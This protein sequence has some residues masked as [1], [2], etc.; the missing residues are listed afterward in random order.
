VWECPDGPIEIRADG[1]ALDFR[2]YDKL[3]EIDLGAVIEHKR[4][5]H[6]PQAQI[7]LT[8]LGLAITD[9]SWHRGPQ[10]RTQAGAKKTRELTQVS[11]D[12][13][14]N[15]R[16]PTARTDT[17]C[18]SRR[19]C[20]D[21][22]GIQNR[23]RLGTGHVRNTTSVNGPRERFHRDLETIR[24]SRLMM[25]GLGGISKHGCITYKS[26]SRIERMW[27]VEPRKAP[28]RVTPSSIQRTAR[29]ARLVFFEVTSSSP[30]SDTRLSC[31]CK[32]FITVFIQL[33]RRILLYSLSSR[34]RRVVNLALH[35][36]R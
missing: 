15:L 30:S 20:F 23:E 3:A 21:V 14:S 24:Q 5:T 31:H 32:V 17:S 11:L 22:T 9:Q 19:S 13:A 28:L 18:P 10:A 34:R 12:Q 25:R 7:R 36:R 35:N 26:I 2:R 4:L 6:A 8:H 27:Y 29:C 1:K 33:R 16:R